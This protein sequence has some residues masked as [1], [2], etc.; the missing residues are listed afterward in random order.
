MIIDFL[1]KRGGWFYL[2][3]VTVV[4]TVLA[5]V[6][7]PATTRDQQV[8]VQAGVI[9]CGVLFILASVAGEVL[10]AM[11]INTFGMVPLL[12]TLFISVSFGIFLMYSLE[13][14]GLLN[15]YHYSTGNFIAEM[16][17]FCPTLFISIVGCFFEKE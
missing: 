8:D 7:Y 16:I 17:F 5:L 1:K 13:F 4:L 2:T 10:K 3:L 14:L 6:F 9:V 11:N 15:V 12:K